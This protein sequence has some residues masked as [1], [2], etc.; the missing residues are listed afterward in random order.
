MTSLKTVL[1]SNGSALTTPIVK[2]VYSGVTNQVTRVLAANE[3][4]AVV[5]PTYT[6]IKSDS[7]LTVYLWSTVSE[8]AVPQIMYCPGLTILDQPWAL[9]ELYNASETANSVELVTSGYPTTQQFHIVGPTGVPEAGP[10]SLDAIFD[11][12]FR[13]HD[14]VVPSVV[15]AWESTFSGIAQAEIVPKVSVGNVI[16][17]NGESLTTTQYGLPIYLLDE[18]GT[19][20]VDTDGTPFIDEVLWYGDSLNLMDDNQAPLIDGDGTQLVDDL[21]QTPPNNTQWLIGIGS[22]LCTEDGNPFRLHGVNFGGM[23]SRMFPGLLSIR[24]LKTVTVD[25]VEQLGMI[26]QAKQLG[27]NA[28]R[29]TCCID[30]TWPN[31]VCESYDSVNVALNPALINYAN[32]PAGA[33]QANGDAVIHPLEIVDYIVECCKSLG[34]RLMLDMHCA[35]PNTDNGTGFNGVWYTSAG[36]NGP[37]GTQMGV[38]RD[39]RNEQQL[40]DAWVVFANRYKDEPTVCAFDLVNEPWATTWDDNPATGWPAAAERIARAIQAVNPNVLIV[41]EGNQ[42]T[43]NSLPVY[44]SGWGTWPLY[45]ENLYNVRSRPITIPVQNKLVYSPHEY[46]G[47]GYN[48]TESY[49]FP[50]TMVEAWDTL[51]GFIVTQNIAPIIIGEWGGNFTGTIPAQAKW[52]YKFVDYMKNNMMGRVNWFHWSMDGSF[53][54]AGTQSVL[55][56]MY[57]T[58]TEA[59]MPWPLQEHMVRYFVASSQTP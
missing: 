5:S 34:M 21:P 25:G 28:I 40:I 33:T 32:L 41:V 53:P 37:A 27:F 6:S 11:A 3:L 23:D 44:P 7:P 2:D 10:D 16:F 17:N 42:I 8:S 36:P 43:P 50:N 35:A 38:T 45:G 56:L 13:R 31:A 20:F 12:I 18:D 15:P 55:G 1:T 46:Y 59:I 58:D 51:W 19:P 52:A 57:Q 48:W 30:M 29:L 9:I 54:P 49:D 26:D 4:Y 14:G 22:N 39:P 24:A 47:P